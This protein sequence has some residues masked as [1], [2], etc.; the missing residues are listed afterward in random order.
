MQ[1]CVCLL[2]GLLFSFGL[3]AQSDANKGQIAGTVYDPNQAVVPGAKVTI[4]NTGTGAVREVK[5]CGASEFR[6]VLLVPAQY[7]V[8]RE[9]HGFAPA[10]MQGGVLNPDSA[11]HFSPLLQLTPT[12]PP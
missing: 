6:A 7:D 3:W 12:T 11:L 9:N 8:T 2:T 5:T 4:K 1:R 10:K